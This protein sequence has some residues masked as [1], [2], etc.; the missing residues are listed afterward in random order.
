MNRVCYA[1]DSEA[2]NNWKFINLFL[3]FILL[4]NADMQSILYQ[5]LCAASQTWIRVHYIFQTYASRALA[6]EKRSGGLTI[7]QTA[8]SI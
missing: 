6:H 4:E 3:D 8:T 2:L 1:A 7:V 5:V